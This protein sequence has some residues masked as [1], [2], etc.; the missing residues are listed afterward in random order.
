MAASAF[1]GDFIYMVMTYIE[2][3]FAKY[4]LIM[5][6]LLHDLRMIFIQRVEK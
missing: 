4:C 3:F 5:L 2:M 6:E 1:N